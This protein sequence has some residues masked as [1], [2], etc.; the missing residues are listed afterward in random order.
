MG[1]GGIGARI[2]MR[3]RTLDLKQQTVADALGVSDATLSRWESGQHCPRGDALLKLA[4]VLD[5]S[6]DYLIGRDDSPEIRSSA[7][8]VPIRSFDLDLVVPP[9][10]LLEA[11]GQLNT[12]GYRITL[13]EVRRIAERYLSPL[14]KTAG[15]IRPVG[16][17]ADEWRQVIIDDRKAA[18]QLDSEK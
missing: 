16:W 10:A 6:A 18:Y 12:N 1:T 8:S 2:R 11:V 7:P 17:T 5:C 14:N 3:R 4:D 13:G 15:A 9:A